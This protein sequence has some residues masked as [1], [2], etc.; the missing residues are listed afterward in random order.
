MLMVLAHWLMELSDAANR[1]LIV[2]QVVHDSVADQS[3]KVKVVLAAGVLTDAT[4]S[5]ILAA[6]R[7]AEAEPTGC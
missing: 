5:L 3:A 1:K 2:E 4:E 7:M 6:L